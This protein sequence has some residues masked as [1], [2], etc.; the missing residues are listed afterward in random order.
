[1]AVAGLTPRSLAHGLTVLGSALA[2]VGTA[3]MLVLDRLL[4][5]DGADE[6]VP[7][8]LLGWTWLGYVLGN[9]FWFGDASVAVAAGIALGLLVVPYTWVLWQSRD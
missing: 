2:A 5:R 4:P 8:V 3:M 6:L 7:A 1:M 9:V